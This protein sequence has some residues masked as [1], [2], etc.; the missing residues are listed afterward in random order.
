MWVA[1]NEAEPLETGEEIFLLSMV[2]LGNPFPVTEDPESTNCQ[3]GKPVRPGYQSQFTVVKPN[4]QILNEVQEGTAAVEVAI[5]QETHILPLALIYSM[6]F[7]RLRKKFKQMTKKDVQ[8]GSNGFLLFHFLM[9]TLR[10]ISGQENLLLYLFDKETNTE[11]EEELPDVEKR[12][13]LVEGI[14]QLKIKVAQQK[15]RM[16]ENDK[17][18]RDQYRTI[19]GLWEE[20]HELEIK[21]LR[22]KEKG[23]EEAR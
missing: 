10:F 18:I 14:K 1:Q 2:L 16:E 15:A 4:K 11:I 20:I 22:E 9:L 23:R 21:A 3:F 6:E 7:S 8:E 13:E 5:F 17:E 19:Q 12:E